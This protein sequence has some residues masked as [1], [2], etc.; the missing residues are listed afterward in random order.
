MY[1]ICVSRIFFLS[2]SQI[3]VEELRIIVSKKNGIL[4]LQ[5]RS[6]AHADKVGHTTL[7]EQ[8]TNVATMAAYLVTTHV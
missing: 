5:P 2:F 8:E 7:L 1:F 6:R 4:G 3:H